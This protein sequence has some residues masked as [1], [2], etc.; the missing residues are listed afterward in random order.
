MHRL[1]DSVTVVF[2]SGTGFFPCLYI[3]GNAKGDMNATKRVVDGGSVLGG[4]EGV[5]TKGEEDWACLW[6]AG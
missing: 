5:E 4:V 2:M 3:G 1:M 6:G